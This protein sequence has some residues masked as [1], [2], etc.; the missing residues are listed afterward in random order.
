MLDELKAAARRHGQDRALRNLLGECRRLLSERGEANGPAIAQDIVGRVDAL[1]DDQRNALL[2][3]PGD[4]LFTRPEGRAGLR[5][6][7]CRAARRP[8]G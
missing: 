1:A 5:P 6:G 2:R 7:L 4:R 3:P 8:T